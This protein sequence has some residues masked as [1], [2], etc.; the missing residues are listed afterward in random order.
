MIT[1]YRA[2][3]YLLGPDSNFNMMKSAIEIQSAAEK[4]YNQNK[5]GG[6]WMIVSPDVAGLLEDL[7]D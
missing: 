3:S 5:R 4:I 2:K 7:D 6:N 1:L